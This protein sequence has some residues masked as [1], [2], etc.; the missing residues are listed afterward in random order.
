MKRIYYLCDNLIKNG[1][2]K[3]LLALI[4]I[5]IVNCPMS[6]VH[7]Q[8]KP[9]LVVGIV[10]DQ[11]RWDYL[12]RYKDRYSEGGFRRM[13]DEGYNCTR[14][15]INYIPA[16]TA[17]GHTS[18]YTGT[19]PAFHGITNNSFFVDGKSTS[20]P[21]DDRMETVGSETKAGRRS[22]HLMMATTMGDELR[23]ATNF[24][25]K[26]IGIAIKD[27]AAILPAGHAANAAYWLDDT[28]DR[29]ITSSYY[30]RELPQ[31]A[32]DFNQKN[33]SKE[34]MK[35]DWPRKMMYA[36]DTYVQSHARDERIEHEVG[37]DIRTT[38]WGATL[39]LDMACAAVEGEQLGKDEFTDMLCV[40]ISSTDAIAHR[41]G[42]N[43]QYIEDAMLW[44]DRDLE[45]FFTFLDE[46]VGKGQWTAFLTA[47]HAGNHNLQW[48]MDNRLPAQ[49]WESTQVVKDLNQK[50]CD[51]MD[52]SESVVKNISSFKVLMDEKL[53]E[54]KELDRNRVA[55]I[56]VRHLKS[57]PMVEY[58][59][60]VERMPD[61]LPE[62][63]RT[64]TRNGFYPGR[65][66]QIQVIPVGGVM[67]AFRY[68][69]GQNLKGA[70]HMLWGP[71]D[72]HIP[73]VFLGNGVPQGEDNHTV[74]ITDIAA[75]ICSLL[76]IQEPSACVGEPIF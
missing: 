71:D 18:V 32:A 42:C 51:E 48:R 22:P 56:I 58:A 75:T 12:E 15:M 44:L 1:S 28:D 21:Y 2:M 31:W 24:R 33:K 45:H 47:D 30:M 26:V 63:I 68:G 76:H 37:Q 69:E 55:D 52:I 4:A 5:L 50:I 10:V 59:F 23:M 65:T 72:T 3:K 17:V 13:M 60:D 36:Q 11:M 74:S 46:K 70:S 16:V 57:L 41:V 20:A 54:E 62:P 67:E 9:K 66:G 19:V 29:F 64:M 39:T 27:R 40:S 34:Y 38:P 73:L 25:S 49:V 6:M 43:S 53:M 35:R 61:Y 14:C 7:G 8:T